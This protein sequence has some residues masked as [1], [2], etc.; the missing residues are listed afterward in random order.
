MLA[1][2]AARPTTEQVD[3]AFECYFFGFVGS[4]AFEMFRERDA[5][6]LV[7]QKCNF[8]DRVS[9]EQYGISGRRSVPKAC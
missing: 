9:A 2:S 6:E 7:S 5:D 8:F 4:H 3:V 1:A